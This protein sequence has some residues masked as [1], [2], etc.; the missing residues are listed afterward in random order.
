MKIIYLMFLVALT[1]VMMGLCYK[2]RSN[3]NDLIHSIFLISLITI[4]A[5]VFNIFT[6]VYINHTVALWAFGIYSAFID[7]ILFGIFQYTKTYMQR[8]D[9]HDAVD[10][11]FFA[12]STI[13]SISL[14]LNGIYG[15]AF[16]IEPFNYRSGERFLL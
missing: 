13:D 2:I 6:I 1:S 4:S 7:W 14:C 9:K 15:H 8:G 16:V 11:I 12:L 3:K 5:A 10:V